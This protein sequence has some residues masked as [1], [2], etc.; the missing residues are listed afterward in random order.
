MFVISIYSMSLS[1][2][3]FR[4]LVGPMEIQKVEVEFEGKKQLW[5]SQVKIKRCRYLEAA[6]CVGMCTNLCKVCDSLCL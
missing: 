2:A 6:G 5:N 3:G 1:Q 4:W